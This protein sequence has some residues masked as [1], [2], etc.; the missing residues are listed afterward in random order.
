MS[1]AGHISP[2]VILPTLLAGARR[3]LRLVRLNPERLCSLTSVVTVMYVALSSS[4]VKCYD[5]LAYI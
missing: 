5:G 2:M 4:E 3:G 1:F